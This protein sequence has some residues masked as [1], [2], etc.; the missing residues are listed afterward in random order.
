VEE[1]KMK[2]AETKEEIKVGKR[3]SCKTFEK[4]RKSEA[5]FNY[6]ST[7]IF[8]AYFRFLYPC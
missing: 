4:L 1:A 5:F 8:L 6:I 3:A 2:E 7:Y